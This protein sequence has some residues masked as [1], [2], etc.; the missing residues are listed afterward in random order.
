MKIVKTSKK[1][2]ENM[3]NI[4]LLLGGV[5]LIIGL[6]YYSTNKSSFKDN[7]SGSMEKQ[8]SNKMKMNSSSGIQAAS[9][10]ES[11]MGSSLTEVSG[12]SMQMNNAKEIVN[13]ADLLPSDKNNEWSNMNPPRDDLKN[14]N[15]LAPEQHIGINTVG[16]SLRNANLQLRSE[17]A[18]PQVPV[19]PFLNTTI[20]PDTTRREL[21]IGSGSV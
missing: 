6:Y 3:L 15:F 17:P 9:G 8:P 1:F 7:L 2:E 12:S 16:N 14:L 11:Q 18:N 10:T 4:V 19:G 21:E 5:I 13:P 20:E